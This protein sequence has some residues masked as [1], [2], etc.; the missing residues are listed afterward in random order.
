MGQVR[1][2]AN[3]GLITLP[4]QILAR[5]SLRRFSRATMVRY[6]VAN[7][8][9]TY[10]CAR[11]GG[12]GN[13]II[14]GRDRTYTCGCA[15]RGLGG[16]TYTWGSALRRI[17]YDGGGTYTCFFMWNTCR[18][19][20]TGHF[21]TYR[22]LGFPL[23]VRGRRIRGALAHGCFPEGITDAPCGD[24][25]FWLARR[26]A[27]LEGLCGRLKAEGAGLGSHPDQAGPHALGP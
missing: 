11:C 1:Q 17:P 4:A 18:R 7:R 25:R 19:H 5:K 24:R 16:L 2:D 6:P 13:I 22:C 15:F 27:S 3:A 23:T 26:K 20:I 14:G 8:L 10:R 9:R 12:R 21:R